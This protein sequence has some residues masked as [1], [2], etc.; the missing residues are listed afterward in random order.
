MG[1]PLSSGKCCK[2]ILTSCFILSGIVFLGSFKITIT[3]NT[4]MSSRKSSFSFLFKIKGLK[5]EGV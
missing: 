4:A 5:K 2:A 1:M 3:K